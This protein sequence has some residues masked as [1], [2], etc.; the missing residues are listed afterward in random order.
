MTTGIDPNLITHDLTNEERESIEKAYGI[1]HAINNTLLYSSLIIAIGSYV[2]LRL[3]W[4]KPRL[5]LKSVFIISA[6]VAIVLM[7][8][9]GIHFI[10]GP[11]IR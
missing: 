5:L 7:L 1:R 3:D 10:P 4:L 8:V 2:A 11:P 9:S 6:I